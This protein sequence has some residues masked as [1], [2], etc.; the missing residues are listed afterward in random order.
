MKIRKNIL[1]LLLL[2]SLSIYS[3]CPEYQNYELDE[4]NQDVDCE[5]IDYTDLSKDNK[6]SK[7]TSRTVLNW[8][9]N[10]SIKN[11][12]WY[13][14]KYGGKSFS[15]S[16]FASLKICDS[17]SFECSKFSSKYL[18]DVYKKDI[19]EKYLR[20]EIDKLPYE[21]SYIHFLAENGDNIKIYVSKYGAFSNAYDFQI[22]LKSEKFP[23]TIINYNWLSNHKIKKVRFV[24]GQTLDEMDINIPKEKYGMFQ[25][26][27]MCIEDYKSR[28]EEK[29]N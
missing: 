6:V 29:F 14:N 27:I 16:F 18:S 20:M 3:Q 2:S 1:F 5:I 28:I 11:A 26:M 19:W 9:E 21:F 24:N 4:F 25:N 10:Y 7:G 22:P 8:S 17:D 15:L 12:R 13:N 23:R